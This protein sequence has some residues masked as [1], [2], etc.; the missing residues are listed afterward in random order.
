MA[1]NIRRRAI[2]EVPC[3]TAEVIFLRTDERGRRTGR[4]FGASPSTYR[5]HIVVQ[6]RDVLNA[7]VGIDGVILEP[8][9]AVTFLEAPTSYQLG[10]KGT[11]L[12]EF[13][14]YPRHPYVDV[15]PG[16]TFTVR[17]GK[18]I[19]AHGVAVSRIDPA[20]T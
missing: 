12:F 2:P 18:K 13:P 10:E 17:E 11:F 4:L 16:S 1:D 20:I 9:Q 19:V 3:V 14:R 5:P 6:S 8:Y 15:Q 7:I